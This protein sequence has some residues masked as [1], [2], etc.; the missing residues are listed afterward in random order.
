MWVP[1]VDTEPDFDRAQDVIEFS[2]KTYGIPRN[3]KSIEDQPNQARP[4]DDPL[5]DL[6]PDEVF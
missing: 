3:P 5:A 4:D 2:R 6:D 1:K